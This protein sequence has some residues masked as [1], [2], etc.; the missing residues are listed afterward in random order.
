MH[1]QLGEYLAT[2]TEDKRIRASFHVLLFSH[3]LAVETTLESCKKVC[4]N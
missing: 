3:F 4:E 1:A 2:G